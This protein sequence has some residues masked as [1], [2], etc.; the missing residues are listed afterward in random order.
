MKRLARVVALLI[1]ATTLIATVSVSA[2]SNG[3]GISPRKDYSVQPGKTISD[4][5]Y[6]SNLSLTQDLQ[7]NMRVIDFGAQ[8]ETGA[9]ALQLDDTASETPWSLKP[10]IKLPSEVK[11]AAGKSANVPISVA[12]PANQGAGS[13][14]SAIE[15]TAV[16]PETKQKVNISAAT[17]SL[18]FVTVPGEAKEQLILKQFGT[19]HSNAEQT[20]GTF[21]GMFF[22]SPKEFA[23]RLQNNGNVAEQPSGS[24]VIKDMFGRTAVEVQDANPKRQLVLIGQT[25]RIQTCIKTS[26]LNSQDPN[27][28]SAKQNVCDDPGLLPGRYTAQIALFYGL[29]GNNTQQIVAS[30]S[31]WYLPWWSIVGFL[32]LVIVIVLLVWLIRRAFGGGRRRYRR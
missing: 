20:D 4:T 22:G 18:V 27:S 8:D 19:W 14:Y 31:F 28:Q 7:V 25:R 3:L 23:Y 6:I 1:A 15:Y 17:A 21:K 12:I 16:N 5:L 29:N 2:A 10:F 30:T 24:M 9:P 13:Y 11:I 32:G 26:V